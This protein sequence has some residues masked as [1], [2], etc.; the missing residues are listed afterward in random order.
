MALELFDHRRQHQRRHHTHPLEVIAVFRQ[1]RGEEGERQ[2]ALGIDREARRT[3][4]DA[5]VG[6]R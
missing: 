5:T 6:S 4:A 2:V 3:R 1:A